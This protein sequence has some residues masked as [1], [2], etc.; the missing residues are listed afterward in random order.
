MV[1]AKG[2]LHWYQRDVGPIFGAAFDGHG[3]AGPGAQA[4]GRVRRDGVLRSQTAGA[5]AC[6]RGFGHV[7]PVASG[8]DMSYTPGTCSSPA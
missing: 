6:V 2:G 5:V 4:R 3:V 7:N 1:W 8:L